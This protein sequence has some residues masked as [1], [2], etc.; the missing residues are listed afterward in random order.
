VIVAA[1]TFEDSFWQHCQPAICTHSVF[2]P[3]GLKTLNNSTQADFTG[4]ILPCKPDR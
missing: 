2:R 4:L 1:E 3:S